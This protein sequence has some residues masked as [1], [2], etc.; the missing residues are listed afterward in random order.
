M[1]RLTVG[2]WGLLGVVWFAL[3]AWSASGA[4]QADVQVPAKGTFTET[5]AD[6]I[7]DPEVTYP[8]LIFE[9]EGAGLSSHFGK[10][11]ALGIRFLNVETGD[12]I[13]DLYLFVRDSTLLHQY[14]GSLRPGTNTAQGSYGLI[15]LDGRLANLRG[16]GQFSAVIQAPH[17]PWFPWQIATQGTIS[18]GNPNR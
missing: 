13:G 11:T 10:Y 8:Y 12:F 17:Y 18:A 4:A 3:A 9:T 15:G 5:R 2:R 16:H 6:I 1:R 7:V 14:R